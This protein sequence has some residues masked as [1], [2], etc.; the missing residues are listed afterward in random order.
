[1][2]HGAWIVLLALLGMG[3]AAGAH[4]RPSVRR[5]NAPVV[6]LHR[7]G[8]PMKLAQVDYRR[9]LLRMP[10][11]WP[12]PA[13]LLMQLPRLMPLLQVEPV[14]PPSTGLPPTARPQSRPH[15]QRLVRPGMGLNRDM[16]MRRQPISQRTLD[17]WLQ[18][19]RLTP[20][21]L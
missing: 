16:I 5:S 9:M 2:K 3:R 21:R 6:A 4:Q 11:T 14:E 17:L 7:L 8:P 12:R 15:L 13:E 18:D 10:P 20:P 1:M 19:A